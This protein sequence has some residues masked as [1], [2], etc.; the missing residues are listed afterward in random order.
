MRVVIVG[1]GSLGYHLAL[2][3]LDKDY[4]VNLIEK[5][6]NRCS[7]LA[8]LLDAE[9]ICGDGTEIEVLADAI[10]GKVDCFIAVTNKDQDNLVASQL[11]QKRF[12]IKKV[13]TRATNPGNLEALRKLG[14]TNAVCST[15]L[16]TRLIEQELDSAGGRLIASLNKGRA[17]ICELQVLKDSKVVG[18]SL[19]DIILPKSS[20]IISL[21][22]DDELIIP[23]GNTTFLPGDEVV[24]I[25][26]NGSQ[27]KLIKIFS[28]R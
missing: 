19:K 26:A 4:E 17:A 28:E 11:A 5:D 8:N 16:I 12:Q 25:C 7:Q 14:M 21:F 20:L 27:K 9:V 24:A 23:E 6:K 18:Q 1:G 15:E 2:S 22:R 10:T 13:I 3:M